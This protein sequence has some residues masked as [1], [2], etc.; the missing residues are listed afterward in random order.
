METHEIST[1]GVELSSCVIGLQVD[2]GLVN[3]TNDLHVIGCPHELH[4]LKSPSGNGTSTT[5][6]LCA[7]GD[8]LAFGIRNKGIRFGWSP[9]T[10]VCENESL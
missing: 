1:V 8:L 2:L 5:A 4:T 9:K 3:E 10:E 6:R 7:P